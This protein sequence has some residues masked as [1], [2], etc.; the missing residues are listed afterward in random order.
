MNLHR[1]ALLLLGTATAS[2]CVTW[3]PIR[4]RSAPISTDNIIATLPATTTT[5]GNAISVNG[6]D[7]NVGDV[8]GYFGEG[9]TV[10]VDSPVDSVE[11]NAVESI[12]EIGTWSGD[13]H[14]SVAMSGS[15]KS[16]K[17]YVDT[18]QTV[19]ARQYIDY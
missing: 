11:A 10:M 1:T 19:F 18:C 7:V 15:S 6:A 2:S 16:S 14:S 5:P 4:T 12:G 8:V 3:G 13:A 17:F 9:V